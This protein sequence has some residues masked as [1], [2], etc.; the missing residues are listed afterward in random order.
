MYEKVM[1]LRVLREKSVNFCEKSLAFKQI[2]DF[3]GWER[4]DQPTDTDTRI[5]GL[6]G[7]GGRGGFGGFGEEESEERGEGELI[8]YELHPGR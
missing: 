8:A 6:G 4:G 2:C 3:E 1:V 5:F 7:V